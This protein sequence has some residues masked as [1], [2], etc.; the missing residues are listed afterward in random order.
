M[1]MAKKFMSLVL[2]IAMIMG[3]FRTMAPTAE[4]A[5][6]SALEISFSDPWYQS[7]V[8]Y[9]KTNGIIHKDYAWDS[10]ATRAGY[11]GIF[12]N[13]LPA[14]ALP[15]LNS[16]ED[17]AIPDVPMTEPYAAAIYKLYRAGIVMGVDTDHNC[18]PASNIKRCEVAVILTHMMDSSTRVRFN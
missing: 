12:A 13:V 17:G 7:Y 10:A 1:I 18:S 11:L 2:A 16:V 14:S 5:D 9:A 6:D 15:E 3:V 8:D 4:A